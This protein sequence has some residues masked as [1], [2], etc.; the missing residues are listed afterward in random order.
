[1]EL[2]YD[3]IAYIR[4]MGKAYHRLKLFLILGN[5]DKE[6]NSLLDEIKSLQNPNGSWPWRWERGNPGGVIETTNAIEVLSKFRI[7]E[8][9]QGISFIRSIQRN[10]GGWSENPELSGYIPK[11]WVFWRTDCSSA[12]FTGEALC[13]LIISV[14]KD[15]PA[16]KKGFNYLQEAQ[17]EEGGWPLNSDSQ[18]VKTDAICTNSAIRAFISMKKSRVSSILKRALEAIESNY[19][20]WMKI[21]Y[22]R[23]EPGFATAIL[24]SLLTLD[25]ENRY[26]T[27]L[28]DYLVGI[29]RQDGGWGWKEEASDPDSTLRC[30]E[31]LITTKT[32]GL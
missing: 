22:S 11:E 20:G 10:D 18:Y 8:V 28:L 25:P 14:F 7:G 23:S 19:E 26:I 4:Q 3:A 12:F 30:L 27:E 2:K 24:E 29:Q 32:V 16:I 31:M 1:M 21:L 17:N 13:A 15:N 9:E 5:E 6:I